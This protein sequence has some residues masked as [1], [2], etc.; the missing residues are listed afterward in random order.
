MIRHCDGTDLNLIE[1]TATGVPCTCGLIFDDVEKMVIFPH[2]R[3]PTRAEK[4]AAYGAMS[5]YM[6]MM[7]ETGSE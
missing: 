3:I 7:E 6:A 2:H 4:E 1:S 5:D